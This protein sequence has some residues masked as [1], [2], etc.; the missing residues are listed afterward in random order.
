MESIE[1]GSWCPG[2]R[3]RPSPSSLVGAGT[4]HA[5]HEPLTTSDLVAEV[6]LA[7]LSFAPPIDPVHCPS[8]Y[9]SETSLV[10]LAIF[11][12]GPLELIILALLGTVAVIL[13]IR[14][15]KT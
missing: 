6:P 1:E 11:G 14:V 7:G 12:I 5:A 9:S 10:P 8:R 4:E 13:A 2:A 15:I 3:R